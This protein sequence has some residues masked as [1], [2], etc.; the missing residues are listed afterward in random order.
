MEYLCSECSTQLSDFEIEL[1]ELYPVGK[2]YCEFCQNKHEREIIKKLSESL[3]DL[4]FYDFPHL[5]MKMTIQE[6]ELFEKDK[7]KIATGHL[8]IKK[9]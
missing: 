7:K 6:Y 3:A 4:D 2:L 1:N 5:K 8:K 9:K